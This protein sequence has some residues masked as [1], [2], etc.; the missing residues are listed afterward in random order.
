MKNSLLLV[1]LLCSSI[2][3]SALD[4]AFKSSTT[5]GYIRFGFEHHDQ[6]KSTQDSVI[7]AKVKY[8]TGALVGI[9]A[10][11]GFYT[12]QGLGIKHNEGVPF[13][14]AENKSYTILGEAYLSGKY[15]NSFLK[16]GRQVIDT[17]FM[18]SD[19]IGMIP[20]L[21]EAY[22]F[23]NT[24]IKDTLIILSHVTKMSGVDA[25][26]VEAFTKLNGSDG[27]QMIGAIHEGIENIALQA[28]YYHINDN[29]DLMYLEAGYDG[30]YGEGVYNIS[31]Q[32]ALQD[33]DNANSANI[34]GVGAEISYDRTGL[35]LSGAYNKVDST[36]EQAADNFFGGGSFFTS[37]EH[38][39]LA[40]AGVNGD[41]L[42]VG[43]SF[44]ASTIGIDG[45]SLSAS[46]LQVN[47][48]DNVEASEF[49][50]VAS[51]QVRE[52]FTIDMI[53]S[54]MDDKKDSSESFK[55][56]RVFV[57]YTF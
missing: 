13:F 19:D 55:N 23:S 34:L 46:N 15:Q 45:L 44:D 56:M 14:S 47:G 35:T 29:A 40:E 51:F 30:S 53:Y 57:N 52:N 27:V 1:S 33:Y 38:L 18:D 3:A 20:N 54:D 21:F 26:V 37:S 2:Y 11:V 12:V 10:G 42:F 39:T 36:G 4:E 25:E 8:E 6:A 9:K 43:L 16:V 49:D 32:Y 24:D 22:T 41:A 5:D 50:F 31:A 7:G 48:D 17:P 28:W